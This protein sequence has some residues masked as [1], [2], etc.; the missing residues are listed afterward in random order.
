MFDKEY[1]KYLT[2]LKWELMDRIDENERKMTASTWLDHFHTFGR[3]FFMQEI[4]LLRERL[5]KL[6]K[7]SQDLLSKLELI[8]LLHKEK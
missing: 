7:I 8:I 2:K 6:E 3:P 1:R 5:D 4:D